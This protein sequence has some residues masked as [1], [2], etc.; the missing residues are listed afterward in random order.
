MPQVHLQAGWDLTLSVSGKFFSDSGCGREERGAP[1]TPKSWTTNTPFLL[2]IY[3][4]SQ[5]LL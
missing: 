3:L 1:F 5:E 2:L 4:C